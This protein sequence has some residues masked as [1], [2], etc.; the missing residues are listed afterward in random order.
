MPKACP[1][2]YI[3]FTT[4]FDCKTNHIY[5]C[6]FLQ[7]SPILS[8]KK[9]RQLGGSAYNKKNLLYLLCYCLFYRQEHKRYRR[10][11]RGGEEY[12]EDFADG[13]VCGV[14]EGPAI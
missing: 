8:P 3:G 2:I 1:Y 9:L 10:N 11:L 13:S 4:L 7:K 12:A 14:A 6:N 5:K